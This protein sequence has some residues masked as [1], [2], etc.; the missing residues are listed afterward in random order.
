VGA[1]HVAVWPVPETVPVVRLKFASAQQQPQRPVPQEDF[2]G[3]EL[4]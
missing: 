4:E 1:V 2:R 3:V